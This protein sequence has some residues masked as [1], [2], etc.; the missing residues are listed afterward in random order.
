MPPQSWAMTGSHDNKP[1]KMWADGLINTHTGYL[2]AKNLVKDV[3]PNC[4]NT[5]DIIVKLTQDAEFLT[6]TKLSELFVSNA[7][8]IQ[9]FF[10]DYFN[11]YDYDGDCKDAHLIHIYV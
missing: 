10:T 6:F 8:N 7:E 4:E 5:D 2:H 1:V 11:V 9:I 3:Y